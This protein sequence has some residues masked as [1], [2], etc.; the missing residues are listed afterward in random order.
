[1]NKISFIF[2]HKKSDKWSTPLSIV[3]EFK[4]RKWKTSIYSLIDND[5]NY[6]DSNLNPLFKTNPD[7][8]MHMDW[9]RHQSPILSQLRSTG[10]YC[11]MESGDDPQQFYRNAIKAPY[12][13]LILSP[14]ATCASRYISDGFRSFW[15][16]H[17]ADTQI[18]K[19]LKKKTKY[20]GVCS[21]GMN[22]YAPIIDSIARNLPAYVVNQNGWIGKEHNEFLNSGL[23]V[24]QQSRHKEITRRIF[25]GMA[26]GKMVLTDR[27]GPQTRIDE[28][29][30]EN[31]DIVYYNTEEE[32]VEKLLHFCKNPDERERIARN[33]YQKVLS[34]HT[35]AHRV[36]FIIEMWKI[37]RNP[38]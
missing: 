13:D 35:V 14:D 10:A 34:N 31:E 24:L 27:L 12:F 8:I 21:R 32:C 20:M 5:Q 38:K 4:R 16:P 15:F 11:V 9:G 3:D 37:A 2:A 23:V 7:I 33:G 29:F 22:Q 1:M 36:D 18:Y 19:P 26:A 6:T 17:F 25:E 30:V 28:L